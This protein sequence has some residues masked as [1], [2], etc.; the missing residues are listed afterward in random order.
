MMRRFN[1]PV[2]LASVVL[3]LTAQVAVAKTYT[4]SVPAGA[5]IPRSNDIQYLAQ[6]FSI[7]TTVDNG[8]P[9]YTAP[10]YLPHGAV[11]KDMTISTYDD[12]RQEDLWVYLMRAYDG[13]YRILCQLHSTTVDI[14]ADTAET[15]AVPSGYA[16]V[17]NENYAYLLYLYLPH[18]DSDE[19]KLYRVIITYEASPCAVVVPM[20]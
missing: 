14:K 19:L 3:L 4:L 7:E 10:L 8:N 12:D 1:L 6:P 17:D 5:F 16:T 20:F 15:V 11:L 9:Y 2:L 13:D 18:S